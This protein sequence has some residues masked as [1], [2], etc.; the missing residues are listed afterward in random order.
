M[1]SVT[2]DLVVTGDES[3]AA[4]AAVEAVQRG[5]RV[6]FVLRVGSS[7]VVPR[8]RRLCRGANG[9]L[10]VIAN[11]EV[12]CVDGIDQVEAVVIRHGRTGRLTAVNACAF[13]SCDRSKTSACAGS[14]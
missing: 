10:L 2:V 1:K 6:L 4:A 3:A 8:A 7:R 13:L 5:Q 14:V 12:V 11:A 9:Q